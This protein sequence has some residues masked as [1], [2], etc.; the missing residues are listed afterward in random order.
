MQF[1]GCTKSMELIELYLKEK[2][3]F[4]LITSDNCQ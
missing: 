1:A 4:F 2:A 3:L